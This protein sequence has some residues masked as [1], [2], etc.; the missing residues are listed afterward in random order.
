[1]EREES[2]LKKGDFK[3]FWRFNKVYFEE[4]GGLDV[5]NRGFRVFG[6]VF[7]FRFSY[8]GYGRRVFVFR[9][10]VFWYSKSSGVFW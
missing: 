5:K 7:F 10:L 9:E 2:V 6:R 8:C 3:D 1:M 4:Y